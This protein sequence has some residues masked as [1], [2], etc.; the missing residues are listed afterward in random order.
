MAPLLKPMSSS[1]YLSPP[2][3]YHALSWCSSRWVGSKALGRSSQRK[4]PS[5]WQMKYG[6]GEPLETICFQ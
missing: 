6:V 5:S 1:P 3:L 4:R 2:N